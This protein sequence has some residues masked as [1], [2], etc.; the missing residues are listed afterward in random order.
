MISKTI[1]LNDIR[2]ENDW[3]YINENLY[4]Y[5]EWE[6]N[7]L[8]SYIGEIYISLIYYDSKYFDMKRKRYVES[9]LCELPLVDFILFS[10]YPTR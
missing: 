4:N 5:D 8:E 2:F 10:S 6:E 7:W 9:T 3:F 1:D